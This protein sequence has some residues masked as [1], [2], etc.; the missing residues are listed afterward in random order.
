M[1]K[2]KKEVKSRKIERGRRA[3]SPVIATIILIMIV[4][5]IA[6]IIILWFR[7]FFKEAIIKEVAGDSKVIE[8]F[9]TEVKMKPILNEDGTFGFTNEGNVPIYAV[10]LKTKTTGGKSEVGRLSLSANPGMT[11]MIPSPPFYSDYEEVK[12][13]PVLLGKKKSGLVA[14]YAC[15]ERDGIKI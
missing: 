5:I 15:P 14:V 7:V 1:N 8:K 11:K 3:V 6:I 13:I 10:D 4:I 2:K 9:C 12:I